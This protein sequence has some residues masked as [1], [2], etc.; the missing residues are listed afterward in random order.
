MTNNRQQNIT[1]CLK[2]ALAPEF[3]EVINESN[4][5]H[6][7]ENSET[8]FKV[9]IVCKQFEALSLI[10]RHRRINTLLK[11]EFDSG[12]HALSIHAYTLNQW[13]ER[14]SQ[15]PKSPNCLDGFKNK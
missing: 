15:S 1:E 6:V 8:H 12:L 9:T 14:K 2:S 5:H 7:P 11:N 4:Q 13:Q 10:E 3:L